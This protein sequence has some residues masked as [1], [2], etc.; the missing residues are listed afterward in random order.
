MP[1]DDERYVGEDREA[2]HR[3]EHG[4]DG[5]VREFGSEHDEFPCCFLV[6]KASDEPALDAAEGLDA[7]DGLDALSDER[8]GEFCAVV[9]QAVDQ[10]HAVSGWADGMRDWPR[11]MDPL[12]WGVV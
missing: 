5:V 10:E 2:L 4:D 8:G 12:R 7:F 6:S 9:E 1:D 11:H 3:S